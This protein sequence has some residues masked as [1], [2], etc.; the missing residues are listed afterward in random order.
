MIRTGQIRIVYVRVLV[1][2][3]HN[4]YLL[5]RVYNL[6]ALISLKMQNDFSVSS[7]PVFCMCVFYVC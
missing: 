5:Y 2:Y 7:L 6:L 4:A 3:L 1:M